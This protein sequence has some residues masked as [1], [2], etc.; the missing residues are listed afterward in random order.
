MFPHAQNATGSQRHGQ[1]S[2][3]LSHEDPLTTVPKLTGFAMLYTH[4]REVNSPLNG[5]GHQHTQPGF[6][7]CVW[8]KY[9]DLK[10]FIFLIRIHWTTQIYRLLPEVRFN[11][12]NPSL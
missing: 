5:Q 2:C 3:L 7:V 1:G 12:L 9:T 8:G 11:Q 10:A 6:G 4:H